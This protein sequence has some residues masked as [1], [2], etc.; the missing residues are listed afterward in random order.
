M[1]C[2][3]SDFVKAGWSI[4]AASFVGEL[5]GLLLRGAADPELDEGWLDDGFGL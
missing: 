2:P 5:S 1:T 4:S 3:L